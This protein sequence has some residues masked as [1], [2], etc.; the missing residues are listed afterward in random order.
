MDG[1]PVERDIAQGTA[2]F[3]PRKAKLQGSAIGI[4]AERKVGFVPGISLVSG[5]LP[6]GVPPNA[7]LG[8][9][10]L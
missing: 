3:F 7:I 8:N 2:A 5:L 4:R 10:Q 6:K 9:F 1:D